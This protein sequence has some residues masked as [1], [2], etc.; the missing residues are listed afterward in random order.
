M[1]KPLPILEYDLTDRAEPS[2]AKPITDST[3]PMRATDRIEMEDPKLVNV[4][5]LKVPWSLP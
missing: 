5:I 1:D 4:R 2:C 3:D